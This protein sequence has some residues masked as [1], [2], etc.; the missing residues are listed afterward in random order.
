MKKDGKMGASKGGFIEVMTMT[1][2]L[3]FL[4]LA[5]FAA[6]CLASAI[7]AGH[8]RAG[9]P[10]SPD[11]DEAASSRLAPGYLYWFFDGENQGDELGHAVSTAG[12]VNGDGYDD[13]IVGAPKAVISATGKIT[14]TGVAY[15]FYGSP[16]GLGDEPAWKVGEVEKGDE[17][18]FSVAA[19]GDLNG[20]GW[21]D[22]VV[23]A[24]GYGNGDNP[25]PERGR[26]YVFYGHPD[27]GPSLTPDWTFE[28]AQRDARLGVAVASAGN[29]NGDAFD[30]LIVGAQGYDGDQSNE[31]AA[32][33]FYGSAAGPITTTY[34]MT[35][36]HQVGA[37]FG[38]SVSSAGDVNGD[39][40]DDVIVG[41]P[42]FDRTETNEGAAFVYY[43]SAA[44]L[45]IAPAWTAAGGQAAAEFGA[46]VSTAGYVN[47]DVYADI[48]VGAPEYDA[49]Q[50][51]QAD[52]GA[53]FVFYGSD[54][55]LSA[56]ANWERTGPQAVSRF[57]AAVAAAGD[58]N[59]D[60]F[61]DVIVGVPNYKHDEP[62]EGG[63]FVY[64]GADTGLGE[65]PGWVVEG[66]KADAYLGSAV[67]TA[68]DVN[69]D[70][71]ADILVG[72]PNFRRDK[73][74]H[75]RAFAYQGSS[76]LAPQFST[77]LPCVLKDLP[78]GSR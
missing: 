38:M 41:A 48:L 6:V 5:L 28:I 45:S 71:Y 27:T 16:V 12:D 4:A 10:L 46:A 47:D 51:D 19:A 74:Y 76:D 69:D 42:Q 3:H 25:P 59:G 21:D 32:F 11:R 22:V 36:S 8:T 50:A 34:W 29:V 52:E 70:G 56:A 62:A 44:G 64:L 68:G 43:G 17:F 14:K 26:V 35:E 1:N 30:D 58:V 39:T 20:D 13:V 60:D 40:Y 49:D 75:G 57:G 9:S 55:G 65:T 33:V 2:R 31:G 67:A 61:D 78:E 53:A 7:G 24:P 66:N 63:A 37:L 18:G 15:I 72:A 77:F 73:V 23:G 54:K